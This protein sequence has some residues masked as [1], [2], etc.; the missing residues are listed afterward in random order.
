MVNDLKPGAE[1]DGFTLGDRLHGGATST[2]FRVTKPGID[3]L[4]VMKV[5]R[6]GPNEPIESIIGFETE[7]MILP[8]ITGP[9]V[10]SFVAVGD[11][12]QTPYLVT[13]WIEGRNIEDM[14]AGGPLAPTDVVRVGAALAE[15]LATDLQDFGF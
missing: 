8:S 3:R 2:L 13:E 1:I 7:A 5:P 4:L 6:V 9:H 15:G 10:P 14:I 11:L 12:A